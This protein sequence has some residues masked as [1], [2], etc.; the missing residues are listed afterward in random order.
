VLFLDKKSKKKQRN[1]KKKKSYGVHENTDIITD[2]SSCFFC[3][4][5]RVFI[6][7]M[8]TIRCNRFKKTSSAGIYLTL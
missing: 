3:G 4:N 8:Q 1:K 5:R 2:K 7:D 6:S